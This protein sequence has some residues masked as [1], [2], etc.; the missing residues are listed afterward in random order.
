MLSDRFDLIFLDPPYAM[1]AGKKALIKI[2]D[3][4]LLRENGIAVYERDRVF[5]GE[6][7]GL[8]KYDERKYGKAYLSFFRRG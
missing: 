3:K 6:I 2:A 7:V 1:D 4:E 8:E 5:E